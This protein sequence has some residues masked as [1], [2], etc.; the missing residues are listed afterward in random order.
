[1]SI[2]EPDIT[3]PHLPLHTLTTMSEQT[4]STIVTVPFDDM[5]PADATPLDDKPLSDATALARQWVQPI[6][7][8]QY[9]LLDA[10]HVVNTPD[11]NYDDT[12]LDN[13]TEFVSIWNIL[14]DENS[15][16]HEAPLVSTKNCGNDTKEISTVRPTLRCT[17]FISPEGKHLLIPLPSVQVW[18]AADSTWSGNPSVAEAFAE[19]CSYDPEFKGT[20]LPGHA[21]LMRQTVKKFNDEY[22]QASSEGGKT[23]D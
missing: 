15:R 8:N 23:R 20:D 5:P 18:N 7:G 17:S 10:W 14:S 4:I 2:Y 21:S 1:V 6:L 3:H 19:K 9:R 16:G 22:N 11:S 13:G 12:T